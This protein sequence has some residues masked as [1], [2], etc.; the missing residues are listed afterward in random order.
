MR[1]NLTL[2][3]MALLAVLAISSCKPRE[4]CPAYGQ[5]PVQKVQRAS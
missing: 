4:K 5:A 3:T 1:K 2:L